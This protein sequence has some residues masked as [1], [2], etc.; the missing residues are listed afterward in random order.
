ML[1]ALLGA[2]AAAALLHRIVVSQLHHIL[3]SFPFKRPT[4]RNYV[5][6]VEATSTPSFAISISP[7]NLYSQRDWSN[8]P[9]NPS[10]FRLWLGATTSPL[11]YSD[12]NWTSLEETT[13]AGGRAGGCKKRI[14]HNKKGDDQWALDAPSPLRHNSCQ[15][16]WN[17]IQSNQHVL[18]CTALHCTRWID[19]V[20]HKLSQLS[21]RSTISHFSHFK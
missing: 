11:I 10:E 21:P 12:S 19:Q 20:N 3:L 6:N 2:A 5:T 9:T 7:G 16:Y 4:I 8:Q 14:T 17:W 1:C 15:E 13:V 18:H